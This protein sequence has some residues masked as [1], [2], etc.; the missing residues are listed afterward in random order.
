MKIVPTPYATSAVDAAEQALR[1][2]GDDLTREQAE[3]LL[4]MWKHTPALSRREVEALLA[5]FP[6]GGIRVCGDAR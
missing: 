2:F 4:S 1:H 5:R 3:V 6:Q